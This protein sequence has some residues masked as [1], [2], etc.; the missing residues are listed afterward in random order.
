[1]PFLNKRGSGSARRFGLSMRS[2]FYTCNTNTSIVTLTGTTC[3]Y[4][5]NYAATATTT[6]QGPAC[7]SGGAQ[8]GNQCVSCTGQA[9]GCGVQ[10][11]G[12]CSGSCSSCTGIDFGG[13][14][15]GNQGWQSSYTAYYINVTTYSCPTNTSA[16][17]LS[18]TT[19][20]YPATYNATLNG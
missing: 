13:G 15:C 8:C 14:N 11:N 17:T 20:V 6:Q 1:M 10:C 2:V 19:C 18:G 9:A 16:V 12:W 4:P 7:Y 3:V 5:A